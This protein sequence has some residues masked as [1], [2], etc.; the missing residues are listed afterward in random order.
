[1]MAWEYGSVNNRLHLH[2]MISGPEVLTSKVLRGVWGNRGIKKVYNVWN[3]GERSHVVRYIAGYC[4]KNIYKSKPEL[5]N[6]WDKRERQKIRRGLEP[7]MRAS[8]SNGFGFREE[9]PFGEWVCRSAVCDR[10][11]ET[12]FEQ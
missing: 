6:E 7:A 1:M 9:I 12:F 5:I 10:D 4:S 2:C 8:Y 11:W 3:Y